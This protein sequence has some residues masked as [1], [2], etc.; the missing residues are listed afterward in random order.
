MSRTRQFVRSWSGGVISPELFGRLDDARYQ[1]GAEIIENFVCKLGGSLQRRPG[2]EFVRETKDSSK[3]SRLI[4]FVYNTGQAVVL[5][6]GE[7]YFRFHTDG[8]T[9][10]YIVARKVASV[11]TGS[12]ES[13]TFTQAHGLASNDAVRMFADSGATVPAGLTGGT[14][15]YAI[16]VDSHTIQVSASSGPGAAVNLTSAGSGDLY[17]YE[18]AECPALYISAKNFSSVSMGA[19]TITTATH[20][21]AN[22]DPIRFTDAGGAVLPTYLD[23]LT[24]KSVLAGTVYYA[25]VTSSTEFRISTTRD[26]ALAGTFL[27]LNGAGSGTPRVHYAYEASTLITNLNSPQ[28]FYRCVQDYPDDVTPG[29]NSAYWQL[30]PF[31]GTLETSNPYDEADLFGIHYTQSGDVKTLVHT[32]YPPAELRRLSATNWSY[33]PIAFNEAL[34][35]PTGASMTPTAGATSAI[36]QVT[37]ATPAVFRTSGGTSNHFLAAGDM[38]Y[39]SEPAGNTIGTVPSNNFYVVWTVPTDSTFT[40]RSVDGGAVIGSTTTTITG[41]PKVRVASATTEISLFYR[42]TV[43][44]DDGRESEGSN[45]TGG[46]N[47]ILAPGAYNTIAWN[48]VSNA[49]RYNVYRASNGVY[50]LIGTTTSTSFVDDGDIEP[51]MSRVLPTFDT[52][53]D[54]VDYPGAVAY[55]EGRRVFGGTPSNPQSIWMTNVGQPDSLAY[56]IP[57]QADDRLRF[58]IESQDASTV[59]HLIPTQFLVALTNSTEYRIGGVNNDAISP[60]SI[61]VRPQSY[62]GGSDV[63]P[64]VVDR[65]VVFVAEM[66][67]HLYELGW[68]ANEGYQPANLCLR[69]PS[70][71]DGQSIVDMTFQ[72]APVPVVWAA[73]S[74]GR[75]LGLT[76]SPTEQV[77]GWHVHSTA[78]DGVFESVCAIPEGGEYRL[79]A[80]V[81]RT[82]DGNTVRNVERMASLYRPATLAE[83]RHVDGGGQ[84]YGLNTSA[85]SVTVT[86]ASAWTAGSTVTI[87]SGYIFRLGGTSSTDVGDRI[88]FAYQGTAFQARVTSV[89]NGTTATA[90]LVTAVTDSAGV[91]PTLGTLPS[92]TTT[93]WGWMRDS[94]SGLDH[95]EG[96]TLQVLADGTLYSKTVASGVI[97]GFNPPAL[98]ITYGLPIESTLRTLPVLYGSESYGQGATANVSKVWLRTVASSPFKVGRE[99]PAETPVASSFDEQNHV[100]RTLAPGKWDETGQLYVFQDQP[101]PLTLVSMT[102]E[103]STGS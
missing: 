47:N 18:V 9:L 27:D 33:E 44:D 12:A 46:V 88:R 31:D 42:V 100:T 72:K 20:G 7:G 99:L 87:T 93:S 8:A 92:I 73:S 48:A 103:V 59:R 96:E 97:S 80:I 55:F 3:A 102:I 83:S 36:D 37:A 23:G 11:D 40:L 67:N 49:A 66:G 50:G 5:E 39:L 15:Y 4:P 57:I 64:C 45:A 26:N 98:R 34:A 71:F 78:A 43:L 16:P 81:R 56:R 65:T 53:L 17:V 21:L 10:L 38:V 82:I 90:V 91:T 29:S 86:P 24:T 77:G 84:F 32:G 85:T 52:S 51:D 75:L 58:E 28:G 69:A 70:L 6:C 35:A 19:D 95:L 74:D 22:G 61:S 101:Y 41:S 2:F 13:I 1:Q 63:Q 60:D 62:V 25:N 14:T 94:L 68:T 79:Y 89:T 76:Y 54:G 30:L